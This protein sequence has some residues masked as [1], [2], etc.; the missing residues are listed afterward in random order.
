MFVVVCKCARKLTGC[1]LRRCDVV[2]RSIV[3]FCRSSLNP[4]ARATILSDVLDSLNTV[5]CVTVYW[6]FFFIAATMRDER[7]R[8]ASKK[9]YLTVA[10]E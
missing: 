1:R 9:S 4:T 7:L 6:P 5:Y 10:M 2:F 8:R 3:F